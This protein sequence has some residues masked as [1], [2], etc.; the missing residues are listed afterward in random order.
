MQTSKFCQG[1]VVEPHFSQPTVFL[2]GLF[3][4]EFPK[5]FN[6]LLGTYHVTPDVCHRSAVWR[7]SSCVAAESSSILSQGIKLNL[8]ITQFPV[9]ICY[10][11]IPFIFF[12][13]LKENVLLEKKAN[14]YD[15]NP[16]RNT[17]VCRDVVKVRMRFPRIRGLKEN[18]VC[19][20]LCFNL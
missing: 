13:F 11:V 18:S 7:E 2:K 3:A 14:L 8:S 9:V 15:I 12:F 16:P 10:W 1:A 19:F 4:D 20:L 6:L 5:V 17:F